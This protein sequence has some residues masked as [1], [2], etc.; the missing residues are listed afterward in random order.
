M[1]AS[2]YSKFTA[3]FNCYQQAD[4]VSDRQLIADPRVSVQTGMAVK[5]TDTAVKVIFDP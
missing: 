5:Q 3:E 4:A 1:L 2:L